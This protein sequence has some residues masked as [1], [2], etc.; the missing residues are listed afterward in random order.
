MERLGWSGIDI[1]LVTGDSYIDSPLIGV[2]V[3]GKVLLNA[4]YRVGII[5][6][7]VTT[8]DTDIR[9]LG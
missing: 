7:P 8:T 2:S 9:R 3:I 5:A 1:I 4:G 6:Q